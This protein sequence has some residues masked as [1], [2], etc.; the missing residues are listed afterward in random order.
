[1]ESQKNKTVRLAFSIVAHDE[2]AILEI[3]LG[4]LAKPQH[5]ICIFVDE[6][7]SANVKRAIDNMRTCS[8]DKFGEEI[9]HL[10]PAPFSVFWGHV[11]LLKADLK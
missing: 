7:V 8:N 1:M 6:K 3:L 11:S 9:V 2:L 4:M 10:F 5:A